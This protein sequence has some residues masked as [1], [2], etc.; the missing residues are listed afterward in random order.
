MRKDQYDYQALK[1]LRENSGLSQEELAGKIGV[2]RV[3]IARAEIGSNASYDLLVK[4]TSYF[5]LPV[6]SVLHARPT[7]A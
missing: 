4:I 5:G 3:T 7:V 1:K 2:G 6:T